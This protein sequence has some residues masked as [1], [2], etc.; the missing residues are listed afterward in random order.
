MK[1]TKYLYIIPLVLLTACHSEDPAALQKEIDGP[2]LLSAGIAEGGQ[3]A[4]TKAGAE[5][6]NHA[7]HLT[8]TS[9]TKLAL[10]VSGTWTGHNPP[11]VIKATTASVG[12][13]TGA[14]NK[15]NKVSCSPV[16]YWDDYGTA[17]PANANTGRTEG[18]TIYGAAINGKTTDPTA[19]A[20]AAP[21]TAAWAIAW[22]LKATN[23]AASSDQTANG[24]TPADKDLLISN[25]VKAGTGDGTYKFADRASGKLLEFT[26]ALSKITVNLKAGAG[27]TGG[28][29]APEVKLTSNLANQTSATEWAYTTGTVNVTDGT[30]AS[31]A[32][33]SAITMY[34]LA[35]P[36]SGYT[37]TKEALVIPGSQFTADNANI[38]RI[39]AD[40][41]IYYVTAEKIRTAISASHAS[42][43]AYATQAGKN[44]IFYI[45]VN[46]TDI[47]VTAT[48]ADW[49]TVTAATEEPVIN[50]AV[51]YGTT[52]G[53]T[54][55]GKDEFSFYRSTALNNG[56]S[57][58][59]SSLK[60][61]DYY[62][63]IRTVKKSGS[64]WL[65]YSGETATPLYWPDHNTHYQFRGVWPNTVTT[66]VTTS[67]RV[68]TS[69]DYQVIKVWNVAYDDETFPSDLQI[70]RPDVDENAECTNTEAGHTK[71]NLYSGGICAT[72]GK[73]NLAFKYMMSQVEVN[74][75]T[76]SGTSAV[77]LSGAVV[78]IVNVYSNGEARL[79]SREVV[80][81]GDKDSY[82]LNT[83]TG[84]DNKRLSAIV[85]QD[86]TYTT[87]LASGNV[88]FKI[89]ITNK[90]GTPDDTTDD[91]TDVYYCDV[92]PILESGK[93]TKVAP[94]GKWESGYHYVYNLTLSKTDVK[95][96]ATLA[97]WTTVTASSDVWF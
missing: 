52:S 21:T 23:E 28:A 46:K 96:T 37:V 30:V 3:E 79:G 41:N 70:G 72:E 25:N 88:M 16:L 80:T 61:G 82:T 9:G 51:D 54:A 55:F 5:E 36:T 76:V 44:Y 77:E 33:N 67:P 81:T 91:T 90:N 63:P 85:P 97:E 12:D 6:D 24:N 66:D 68:E 95:V 2:I 27:F 32:G 74:L 73:I 38:V 69:G 92:N 22:S 35:T 86:L 75:S 34:Q 31:Q 84:S 17:D 4:V 26:H 71:T 65:M 94:N 18:L 14:D 78:E 62:A 19:T 45:I 11:S 10:Q 50:V 57:T 7:R 56:Y 39:N 47:V 42:E 60:V 89:T 20:I 93:S 8:L 59:P 58:D 87:K 64:D 83:V 1:L 29:F 13:A 49:T 43:G 48:V 53:G 15:H 40:G